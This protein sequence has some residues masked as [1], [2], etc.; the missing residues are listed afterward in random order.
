MYHKI[1]NPTTGKS[2]FI[3]SIVG[4]D[5]LQ[6]YLRQHGGKQIHTFINGTKAIK[7]DNGMYQ[8][9]KGPTKGSKRRHISKRVAKRAFNKYWNQRAKAVEGNKLRTRGVASARARDIIYGTTKNLRKHSG[10]KQ[11]PGRLEYQGVDY[12]SRRYQVNPISLQNLKNSEQKKQAVV[13]FDDFLNQVL[14]E[15][16]AKRIQ[17]WYRGRNIDNIL[18]LFTELGSPLVC[19]ITGEYMRDPVVSI[20]GYTYERQAII[21]W[22]QSGNETSPMTREK[23]LFL[24]EWENAGRVGLPVLLVTNLTVKFMVALLFNKGI[25]SLQDIYTVDGVAQPLSILNNRMINSYG[26]NMQ[27]PHGLPLLCPVTEEYIRYPVINIS[28]GITYEDDPD[29]SDRIRNRSVENMI[30]IL[31]D[32]G[33]ISDNDLYR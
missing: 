20:D 16:A 29:I 10:Y 31:L 22:L 14:Q 1:I 27:L 21:H 30:T 17:D 13:V 23:I 7:K 19:P 18:R 15:P 6:K 33:I 24:D 26:D 4:K 2:I 11:N 12:G 5:I 3:N 8:I 9:V 32:N 25:I 28:S